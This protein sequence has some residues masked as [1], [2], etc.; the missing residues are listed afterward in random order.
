MSVLETVYAAAVRGARVASPL[1]ARGDSKIARAVRGRRGVVERLEAWARTGR[2]RRRHLL[3]I[4]APS[5]GEGLQARAVLEA[6]LERRPDLQT[7][8]THFSPSAEALASRMPADVADYLPWDVPGEVDPV[9]DV[10]QPD[11]VAFTKTEVWPVLSR[12]ARRRGIPTALVAATLPED[13]SRL[14]WPAREV[15]RPALGR[16]AAVLAIAP[17]DAERFRRLGARGD[18]IQVTGDPGIDSAAARAGATDPDAA[19][20]APFRRTPR[21]TIV[22]GST[23][24]PDE[25]VLVEA[26]SAVREARPGLRMVV[27]PHEPTEEHLRPL[28][29]ALQRRGWV[30]ARLGAVEAAGSTAGLDAVV[31]DRVGVLAQ[32]Y[33]VGVVAYVGGG[34]HGDGLHSVLEPAAAGLPVTFGPRHSNARAAADLVEEGGARVVDGPAALARVLQGWLSDEGAR[35]RWGKA[36]RGYIEAHR[37]AAVRTAERVLEILGHP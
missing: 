34:F 23:W 24:P 16:L 27:A 6:T 3:W 4:H 33:S 19:W 17:D 18:R 21:P 35:T 7:V 37:G 29:A 14:R 30:T 10:L 15:L 9:L 13:S 26:V 12:S 1:V 5:V 32:L 11:L 2:D 8:F 25:E 22:A 36:A 31:V 28:E 20:L